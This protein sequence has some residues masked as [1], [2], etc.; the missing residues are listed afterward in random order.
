M[1]KKSKSKSK[2]NS[3]KIEIITN[4]NKALV[5]T[6]KYFDTHF[7]NALRRTLEVDIPTWA[8]DKETIKYIDTNTKFNHEQLSKIFSLIPILNDIPDIDYENVKLS[9]KINYSE[10]DQTKGAYFI[11]GI[12]KSLMI[13]SDAINV[14][15]TS[16]TSDK[17][18]LKKTNEQLQKIVFP[19]IPIV[20]IRPDEKINAEMKLGKGISKVNASFKSCCAV[21]YEIIEPKLTNENGIVSGIDYTKENEYKIKLTVEPC[22]FPI[23]PDGTFVN[24]PYPRIPMETLKI[25][26]NSIIGRLKKIKDTHEFEN[27]ETFLIKGESHTIGELLQK[28]ILKEYPNVFCAYDIV[29]P[30]DETLKFKIMVD[31]ENKEFKSNKD[32]ILLIYKSTID[33]IINKFQE[34]MKV[35]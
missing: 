27:D 4:N 21:G 15:G 1:E 22:G 24:I 9:L 19:G 16:G 7:A 34:I 3:P 13:Y 29:H 8:I 5:F 31:I 18:D 20:S 30:L 17:N 2:T 23:N 33:K 11:P 28:E 10:N 25:A 14:L 32:K 26:I 6:I 12:I 35:L